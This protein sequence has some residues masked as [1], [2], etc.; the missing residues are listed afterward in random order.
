MEFFEV[1]KKRHC[2]RSFNPKK[3]VSDLDIEKI[4]DAGKSAPSAGG[5]YP[6]KFAVVKKQPTKNRLADSTANVLHRMDFI[7]EAP[8][9]IVVYADVEKTAT[10]YGERGKNLY[11]I[12][13]AAVATENIFL[14]ATA[15]GLGACWVGAFDENIVRKILHLKE[16][17][18]PMVIMPIGYRR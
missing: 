8:V 2:T 6:V 16:D 12:Q 15:L 10:K 14:A 17:Q 4:I 18:R 1:I 5:I 11:V 3:L 7:P 13:D 9:V